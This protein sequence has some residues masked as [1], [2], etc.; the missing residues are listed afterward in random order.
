ML[1]LMRSVL[2]FVV[3]AR[4]CVSRTSRPRSFRR[5]FSSW[6]P[7]THG[8]EPPGGARLADRQAFRAMDG[9]DFL[10]ARNLCPAVEIVGNGV[11][12][13]VH[14]S[15]RVAVVE[16]EQALRLGIRRLNAR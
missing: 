16:G 3:V 12:D 6:F 2:S 10:E 1:G 13:E 4:P 14:S 15:I 5:S 7:G 11:P 8:A 9:S